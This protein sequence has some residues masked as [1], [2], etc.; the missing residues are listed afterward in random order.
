MHSVRRP[1]DEERKKAAVVVFEP[2]SFPMEDL[3]IRA[4][5]RTWL[6]AIELDSF[7]EQP[8]GELVQIVAM[9]GP[10]DEARFFQI[11]NDGV[12]P[13]ARL[14]RIGSDD[15]KVATRIQVSKAALA[16]RKKRVLRAAA[17]MDTAEGSAHACMFFDKADAMV[18]IVAAEQ[19]VIEQCRKACDLLLCGPNRRCHDRSR[20]ENAKG[21]A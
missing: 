16:Q 7:L 1:F 12:L 18:E 5:T 4:L 6:W 15:F 21:P 9:R 14:F 8:R 17:R 19:N 2:E 3:S 20:R 11:L 10:T 13:H